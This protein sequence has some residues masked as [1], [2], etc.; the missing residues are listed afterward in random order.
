M[1]DS[2]DSNDTVQSEPLHFSQ[3]MVEE[4]KPK[5]ELSESQ[6]Q[7]Y[8]ILEKC[9]KQYE[10]FYQIYL[11]HRLLNIPLSSDENVKNLVI[12]EPDIGAISAENKLSYFLNDDRILEN[13]SLESITKIDAIFTTLKTDKICRLEKLHHLLSQSLGEND[14]NEDEK[15]SKPHTNENLKLINKMLGMKLAL[16]MRRS[17]K[18]VSQLLVLVSTIPSYNQNLPLDFQEE[19]ELPPW[20]KVLALSAAYTKS[21]KDLQIINI[22]TLFELI[23]IVKCQKE[24]LPNKVQHLVMLPLLKFGHVTYMENRTRIFQL[25]VSTLWDMLDCD[26][27]VDLS[28]IA[29]LLYQLHSCLDS[30]LVERIISD[31]IE[32]SHLIWSSS[33][34][35]DSDLENND[36]RLSSYKLDRLSDIKIMLNLP[37]MSATNLTSQLSEKQ[38][39]GFKKFELLWHLGRDQKESFDKILLKVYDHL[40]LP[41]HISIRTFVVKWLKESLL[42]GDLGRFL[43]PLMKVMLSANTKRISI[44]NLH[45]LKVKGSKVNDQQVF[46]EKTAD[47]ELCKDILVE[48]EVYVIKMDDGI[49]RN[50]LEHT[51]RKSPIGSLPKKLFH[52]ATKNTSTGQK[53]RD[54][55]LMPTSNLSSAPATSLDTDINNISLIVNP[56]EPLEQATGY[57]SKSCPNS[58]VEKP[59]FSDSSSEYSTTSAD[60]MSDNEMSDDE[61]IKLSGHTEDDLPLELRAKNKKV[62]NLSQ[63]DSAVCQPSYDESGTAADEYFSNALNGNKS[64]EEIEKLVI[65]ELIETS[66]NGGDCGPDPVSET[67]NLKKRHSK[68]S[69]DSAQ[70][71]ATNRESTSEHDSDRMREPGIL[72]HQQ[73]K[74]KSSRLV[75]K[76]TKETLAKGKANVEIFKKNLKTDEFDGFF[77]TK[78]EKLHPFHT[79]LLLYY[80]SY[81]T[82]QV[83]YSLETLRNLML[84]GNPKLFLCL[85]INTAV[86]EPQLKHLLMRHRKSIFGKGKDMQNEKVNKFLQFDFFSLSF[87]RL[88]WITH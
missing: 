53:M 28:Q 68:T 54:K 23:G 26:K 39:S 82:K 44:S 73:K 36:D 58:I 66:L 13:S 69:I 55:G 51:K 57:V 41:Q 20:L 2:K 10:I 56:L 5:E 15:T 38:S 63:N 19:K 87:L 27:T 37:E 84:A 48:N 64:I 8:T 42:R 24:K 21:D 18:F 22:A 35:V 31:R 75:K 12:A 7:K 74:R 11:S 34:L 9:S 86:S 45:L 1:N 52:M 62:Y 3:N 25:L 85:S 17:V 40:G 80:E 59:E 50:H 88:Q 70:M 32:N 78:I 29:F 83:L 43:M 47:H 16:S 61:K 81:D 77:S 49:V 71:S 33:D 6:L 65:H 76:I 14:S 67:G 79:H 4:Q 46:D 60:S 30:G 72:R